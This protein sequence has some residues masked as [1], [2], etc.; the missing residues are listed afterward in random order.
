MQLQ[1]HP[2]PCTPRPS[3]PWQLGGLSTGEGAAGSLCS[4][5]DGV[6]ALGEGAA[7]LQPGSDSPEPP[8]TSPRAS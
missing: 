5:R 3:S 1:M 6:L 2:L 8:V 4:H 7:H